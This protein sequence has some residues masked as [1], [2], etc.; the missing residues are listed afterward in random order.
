MCSALSSIQGHSS[1]SQAFVWLCCSLRA[2]LF[3]TS[4]SHGHS[5]CISCTSSVLQKM[6]KKWEIL[7]E[8]AYEIPT[9]LHRWPEII[10]GSIHTYFRVIHWEKNRLNAKGKRAKPLNSRWT[11]AKT[12]LVFPLNMHHAIQLTTLELKRC[13]WSIIKQGSLKNRDCYTLIVHLTLGQNIKYMN[14]TILLD[15][16]YPTGYK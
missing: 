6:D 11:L 10:I 8:V 14:K 1:G 15:T 16:N 7:L 3:S 4:E 9:R 2:F 12:R 13:K 5:S